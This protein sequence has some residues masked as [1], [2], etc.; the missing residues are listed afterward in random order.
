VKDIGLPIPPDILIEA[1]D[2]PQKERIIEAMK[3]QQQAQ[4]EAQAGGQENHE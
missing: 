4:A 3:Q 2:L 1:S